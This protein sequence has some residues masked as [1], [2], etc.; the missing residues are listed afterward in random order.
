MGIIHNC[1]QPKDCV[2]VLLTISRRAVGGG[3]PASAGLAHGEQDLP[4]KS[5]RVERAE[6]NQGEHFLE[7]IVKVADQAFLFA[8]TD[9]TG[10]LFMVSARTV[11]SRR[12]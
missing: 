11:K 6:L 8:P 9:Q 3:I 5:Y 7:A 1:V 12:T 10:M 4:P 2:K